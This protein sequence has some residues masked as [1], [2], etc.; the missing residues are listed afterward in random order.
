MKRKTK[1]LIIDDDQDLCFLLKNILQ[2]KVEAVNVATTLEEGKEL[3][4]RQKPDVIFLDNNLP[5]G[6]GIKYIPHFKNIA[7]EAKIV[8]ISAMPNA[9]E[10]A[11]ENGADAFVEKPIVIATI[12]QFFST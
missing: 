9:K 1:V 11:I 10:K 6:Q 2:P 4:A 5:D 7:P 3:L 8:M 12:N